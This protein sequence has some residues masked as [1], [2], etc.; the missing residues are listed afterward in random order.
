MAT[1]LVKN[2]SAEISLLAETTYIVQVEDRKTGQLS[3]PIMIDTREY[4]EIVDIPDSIII[5]TVTV[6]SLL[7]ISALLLAVCRYCREKKQVNVKININN[8]EIEILDK[9]KEPLAL[10]YNNLC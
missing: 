6:I 4:S 10:D 1:M 8:N 3:E 5:A 7:L 9:A 2:P